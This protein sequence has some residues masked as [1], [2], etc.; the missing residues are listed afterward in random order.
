[1]YAREKKI[2]FSPVRIVCS[3]TFGKRSLSIKMS[4]KLFL[5]VSVDEL[6]FDEWWDNVDDSMRKV[7]F[8]R[9]VQTNSFEAGINIQWY[10]VS[11][12]RIII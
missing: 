1:M 11:P 7:S 2:D 4:V 12:N 6:W 8:D 5:T 3:R 9:H 10:I